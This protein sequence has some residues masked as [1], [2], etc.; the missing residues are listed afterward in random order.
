MKSVLHATSPSSWKCLR[1]AL[2]TGGAQRS[3]ALLAKSAG[4]RSE[5]RA[6]PNRSEPPRGARSLSQA[7]GL[8]PPELKF[9]G[10]GIFSSESAELTLLP[11]LSESEASSEVPGDGGPAGKSS[12]VSEFAG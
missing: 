2:Y 12:M 9:F 7:G 5:E 3:S 10:F 6:G 4:E 1:H 11:E 8:P